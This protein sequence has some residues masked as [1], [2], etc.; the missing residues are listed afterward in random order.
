MKKL[1]GITIVA[2][3]L[4]SCGL[5]FGNYDHYQEVYG[6]KQCCAKTAQE[7]YEYEGLTMNT[8]P[9]IKSYC[10]TLELNEVSNTAEDMIYWINEDV[11]SGMIDSITAQSY[12]YNLNQI[13]KSVENE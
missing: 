13:I 3:L 2:S 11:K 4:S 9:C 5:T 10:I 1:I 8:K 6:N 12:V 7:V